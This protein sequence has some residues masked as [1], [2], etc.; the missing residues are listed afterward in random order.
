MND[1]RC[2]SGHDSFHE[3]DETHYGDHVD[4]EGWKFTRTLLE[5][6]LGFAIFDVHDVVFQY[7]ERIWT[8]FSDICDARDVSFYVA[9]FL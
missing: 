6:P 1:R 7:P 8:Y 2:A 3:I 4:F 5:T 9:L